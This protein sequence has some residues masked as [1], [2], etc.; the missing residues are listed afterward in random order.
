MASTVI[1]LQDFMLI[2]HDFSNTF[3]LG[4][5]DEKERH[6]CKKCG[7]NLMHQQAHERAKRR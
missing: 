1:F 2:C 4:I 7:K 6:A 3:T 5:I